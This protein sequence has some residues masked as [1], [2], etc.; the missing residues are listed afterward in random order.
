MAHQGNESTPDQG[1][2]RQQRNRDREGN[3][4]Q[5]GSDMN[6]PAGTSGRQSD[7][8]SSATRRIRRDDDDEPGLNTRTT[9]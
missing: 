8:D 5:S 3:L 6:H 1:D 9:F 2:Q 7:A 4:G